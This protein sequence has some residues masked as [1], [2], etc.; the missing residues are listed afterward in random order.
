L[1]WDVTAFYDSMLSAAGVTAKQHYLLKNIG[2][3][4]K[5]SVRE[6]ADVTEYD[7]STLARTL[8]P[9][10]A[11]GLVIDMRAPGTRN[12]QLELTEEGWKAENHALEL[13]SVAQGM[14][15]EALGEDGMA[16]FELIVSRFSE[17]GH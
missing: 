1:S 16:A 6:L 10:L 11:R 9:L 2:K 4:G 13:W 5:C 12:R 3:A 14:V 7:R 17:L 15:E 8:K